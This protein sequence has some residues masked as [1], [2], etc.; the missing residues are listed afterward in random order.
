MKFASILGL[1]TLFAAFVVP[2]AR[3][4]EVSCQAQASKLASSVMV[5][6]GSMGSPKVTLT[7]EEDSESGKVR[8]Y[9]TDGRGAPV[10]EI[11]TIDGQG[12]AKSCIV[13]GL[14]IPN[15]G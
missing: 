15:A 4:A 12:G 8:A 10:Y 14:S 1:A 13:I 2:S 3:A 6:N 7:G 9:R 5:I 11:T